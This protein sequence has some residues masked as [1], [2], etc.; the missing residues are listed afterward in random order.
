MMASM[1]NDEYTL[2]ADLE[3]NPH[4]V[5]SMFD[6]VAS[7]YDLMNTLMSGG[8]DHVWSVALRKAV[9]PIPSDVILD[10]AAG[11]GTSSAALAVTGARVIA[12]DLSEGMIEVGRRR[13]PEL[14]FVQGDATALEFPDDFFDAVTIS[15][16]LRNVVDTEGALREMA[17]VTRPGGRLVVCEFST[18]EASAFRDVYRFYL[19]N[20]IS[21]LAD[22]ASSDDVA[23]DYLVESIL[24]WPSQ[25]A[26][27]AMI[28][29]CGWGKVE[30]RNLTGGIVALHRATKPSF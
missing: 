29:R 15:Y 16:G 13:H 6:H 11:T 3:K 1:S 22:L 4:E 17:R 20:V 5:A 26:L 7:R 25:E 12:C 8:M 24:D 28:G 14:E 10:L 2:R 30:Y 21:R 23:Y 27:G 18:P 9:D 19:K